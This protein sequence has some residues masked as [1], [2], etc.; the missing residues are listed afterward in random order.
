MYSAWIGGGCTYCWRAV[1][2][3]VERVSRATKLSLEQV[4][5][6][7]PSATEKDTHTFTLYF[8]IYN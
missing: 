6:R 3:S 7:T 5:G 2:V 1:T 4:A 8:Y